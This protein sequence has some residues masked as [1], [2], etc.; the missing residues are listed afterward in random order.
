MAVPL[1]SA[2]TDTT[3]SRKCQFTF[4]PE[5][6]SFQALSYTSRTATEHAPCSPEAFSLAYTET[7]HSNQNETQEPFEP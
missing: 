7:P 2:Q 5:T 1:T 4:V 6:S 3:F